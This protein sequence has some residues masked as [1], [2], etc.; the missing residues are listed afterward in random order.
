[1]QRKLEI[2]YMLYNEPN[3]NLCCKVE[4]MNKL[5]TKYPFVTDNFSDSI[6]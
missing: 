3:D 1:M 5:R 6:P 4:N 2:R